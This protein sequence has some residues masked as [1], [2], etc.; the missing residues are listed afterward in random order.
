MS[1]LIQG[2]NGKL[3]LVNRFE[4]L[5]VQDAQQLKAELEA[6]LQVVNQFLASEANQ[7]AT[8]G[9]A[10]LPAA[11]AAEQPAQPQE[12]AN[13]EQ[14]APADQP[15]APAETQPSAGADQATT[16]SAAQGDQAG[17]ATADTPATGADALN[18]Q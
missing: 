13:G 5:S 15:A 4:E 2:T 9:T 18:M 10:E 11:P 14:P 12:Q 1:R 8:Q 16:Q 6:D 7:T 17:S 3:L